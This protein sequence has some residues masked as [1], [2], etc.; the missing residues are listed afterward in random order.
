[1]TTQT[2]VA[3]IVNL[4]EEAV[5]NVKRFLAESPEGMLRLGVRGGGCSGFQYALTLDTPQ[6]SDIIYIQADVHVAVDSAAAA[7]LQGA[8]LDY[9]DTVEEQGFVFDNPNATGG[10]GCGSSFRVDDQEGCDT[11][12]PTLDETSGEI[13]GA[14]DDAL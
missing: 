6:E 9:K 13:Y 5:R 12:G 14:D 3:P 4:T 7:Y 1:M 11:A 8:T 2:E 10:C